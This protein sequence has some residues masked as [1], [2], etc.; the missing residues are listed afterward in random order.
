MLKPDIRILKILKRWQR[1]M[2]WNQK[3]GDAT[4]SLAKRFSSGTTLAVGSSL[5]KGDVLYESGSDSARYQRPVVFASLQQDLLKNSFGFDQRRQESILK[6]ASSMQ[7]EAML[8][9]LSLLVVKVIVDYWD[10]VLCQNE[11]FNADNTAGGNTQST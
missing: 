7:R 10:L 5:E 4:V 6:N 1:S 8:Y 3:P 2:V 9:Q 11:V